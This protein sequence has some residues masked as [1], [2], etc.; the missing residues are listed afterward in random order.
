MAPL[1]GAGGFVIGF[2]YSPR[3]GIRYSVVGWVVVLL[4]WL[5]WL[6][7]L[8]G[9]LAFGCMGH[10]VFVEINVGFHVISPDSSHPW[11]PELVT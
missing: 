5:G 11:D 10:F 9:L 2:K 8:L 4:C 6:A 3:L 1:R 7:A